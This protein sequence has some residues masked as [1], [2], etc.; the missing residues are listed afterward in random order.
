MSDRATLT[1]QINNCLSLLQHTG[2]R[3]QQVQQAL[4]QQLQT[5]ILLVGGFCLGLFLQSSAGSKATATMA[6][7]QAK[8]WP[9]QLWPTQLWPTQ[10]PVWLWTL[11]RWSLPAAP[12]RT[13]TQPVKSDLT[14][15]LKS[16]LKP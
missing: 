8:L 4:W 13:A 7:G 1:R 2:V 12:A 9:T 16:E 14:S 11:W 6:L 15:D 10:L 3:R 5:P